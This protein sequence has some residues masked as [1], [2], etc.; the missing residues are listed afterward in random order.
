MWPWAVALLFHH[1]P[2]PTQIWGLFSKKKLGIAGPLIA[3]LRR[4]GRC[5]VG[6]ALLPSAYVTHRDLV[7]IHEPEVQHSWRATSTKVDTDTPGP[8]APTWLVRWCPPDLFDYRHQA[9]MVTSCRA[10][11]TQSGPEMH[12]SNPN[13]KG[14]LWNQPFLI[15]LLF[16]A[17]I[18]NQPKNCCSWIHLRQLSLTHFVTHVRLAKLPLLLCA[19]TFETNHWWQAAAFIATFKMGKYCCLSPSLPKVLQDLIHLLLCSFLL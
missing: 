6:L 3:C 12:F 7:T 10:V 4:G 11:T 15:L 9:P 1:L 13:W 8:T 14:H 17:M 18:Q 2:P 5:W 19:D 16:W